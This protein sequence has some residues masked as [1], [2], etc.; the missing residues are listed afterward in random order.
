MF[1]MVFKLKKKI[2]MYLFFLDIC[3]FERINMLLWC[4]VYVS[5]VIYVWLFLIKI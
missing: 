2:L 5:S 1:L 4:K 3:L